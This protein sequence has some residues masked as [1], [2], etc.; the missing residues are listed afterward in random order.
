MKDQDVPSV[1]S[2]VPGAGDWFPGVLLAPIHVLA[3]GC[4]GIPVVTMSGV[5]EAKCPA[6]KNYQIIKLVFASKYLFRKIIHCLQ[7]YSGNTSLHLPKSSCPQS[8]QTIYSTCQWQENVSIHRDIDLKKLCS[9]WLL[10][11]QTL[12]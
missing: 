9:Q 4:G 7:L 3:D 10:I 5:T 12:D 2:Q 6:F 1:H 11:F 8:A